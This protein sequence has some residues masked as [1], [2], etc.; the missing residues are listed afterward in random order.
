MNWYYASEGRQAGP[1]NEQDL[2]LQVA[3]GVIR[4]DTLVWHDG[5]AGWLPYGSVSDGT[6][7]GAPA[8]QP[9]CTHCGR[10][11]APEEMIRFG[12][13]WVCA[14]CKPAFVQG[15]KEGAIAQE[16]FRYGGFWIRFAASL[17]DGIIMAVVGFIL[18]FP[19]FLRMITAP[20]ET[21]SF[22]WLGLQMLLNL[23]KFVLSLG[24]ETWFVGAFGATP[25]KMVCGLRIVM[26]DGSRVGYAR[27]LARFFAKI[28]SY[29]T[30][31]IGFIMAAFDDEK[32]ALHDRICE[33]RVVK[34]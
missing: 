29:L 34:S 14:S 21:A 4:A 16:Q 24:Y 19:L 2:K 26:P 10:A 18:Q 5:M 32:R 20:Q 31:F 27:A 1:L 17:I 30:L 12:D 9:T 8:P 11:F 7:A 28:I 3:A 25:G 23:I 13:R 33:T 6:A 15:L 22:K